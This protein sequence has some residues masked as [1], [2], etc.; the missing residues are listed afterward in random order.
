MSIRVYNT[1]T[2]EKEQLVTRKPGR[3]DIYQCGVTPYDYTHM[4]HARQYVLWDVIRRYLRYR[5]YEVF[6]VQNVTDIDDKI[7]AKAQSLGIS[8]DELARRFDREYLEVMDALGVERPDVYPR[9]TEHI[10][11]I[12]DV[13]R[14]LVERGHAYETVNGVYFDVSSFPDYGKLSGRNLDEMRAG[15]RVEVDEAKKDPADFAL[16]KKAKPGEPAWDSPW[17]RGRPGWHIECSTLAL[18]YLGSG[19]D[20]HGGGTDLIFPHH[21]NEIA[22]A[23]AYTGE[24]PFVRYWIHHEMV[25]VN[26]EKM[27]KS[28]GNL[29]TVR[30]VLKEFRPEDIRYFLVSVHYRSPANFGPGE[31][32]AAKSARARLVNV[33]DSIDHVL[34]TPG[35]KNGPREG[36]AGAGP[37]HDPAA[38]PG[39]ADPAAGDL[40]SRIESL[41]N[42]FIEAMDDDF[43]TAGALGALHSLAREVNSFINRRRNAAFPPEDLEALKA[44]R[45]TLWELGGLLGIF[46]VEPRVPGEDSRLL[47][48]LVEFL[49]ELR[50]QARERK[51]WALADQIRD[52]LKELGIVLEDTPQ[53]TRWKM[54]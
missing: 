3:V 32:N 28:L 49:V 54:E 19:F 44:A 15:A 34:G 31:L 51:E 39:A 23:E 40:K 38:I 35:A 6:C 47:G 18:K 29:F 50:G 8:P 20:M 9:V 25:N 46:G 13:I 52:R 37:A 45:D 24:G 14:G 2:R 36:D 30:D 4:G 26:Q 17:G 1:L 33:I 12:I 41:R 10:S 53:G 11:D 27:S 16:W 43:N 42:S 21:E 5:G 22:Q 48:K 7:I